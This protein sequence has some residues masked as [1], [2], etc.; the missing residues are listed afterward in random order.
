[1]P[2]IEYRLALGVGLDVK[3]TR[4]QGLHQGPGMEVSLV[5]SLPRGRAMSWRRKKRL[6]NSGTQ[7]WQ[8]AVPEL[9]KEHFSPRRRMRSNF[10]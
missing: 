1:M 3:A 2:S 9:V 4:E 10:D 7:T 6:E 8:I 5:E